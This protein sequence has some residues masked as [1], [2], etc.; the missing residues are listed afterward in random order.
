MKNKIFEKMR[1]YGWNLGDN[2]NE[3]FENVYK[4]HYNFTQNLYDYFAET[5]DINVSRN[6]NDIN[7]QKLY[8]MISFISDFLRALNDIDYNN[9]IKLDL[10]GS[11]I[12]NRN[13][14]N[15]QIGKDILSVV[16]EDEN[17]L[18][19]LANRTLEQIEYLNNK[20]EV[21]NFDKSDM[22]ELDCLNYEYEQINKLLEEI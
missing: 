21:C 6:L 5:D 2:T 9:N 1:E 3:D 18:E 11:F 19:E 12:K 14:S 10:I 20:E 4:I 7:E 8:D 16:N 22:C 17:G 13:I 15:E